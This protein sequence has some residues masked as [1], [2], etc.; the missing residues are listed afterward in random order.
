MNLKLDSVPSVLLLFE[1][2]YFQDS[3]FCCVMDLVNI[4]SAWL[5]Y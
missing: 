4:L 1:Y 2:L 5:K 3:Q